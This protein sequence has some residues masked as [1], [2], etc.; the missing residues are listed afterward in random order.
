MK[1]G[2]MIG[3]VALIIVALIWH[4]LIPYIISHANSLV[5]PL[6][7]SIVCGTNNENICVFQNFV[8]TT[9]EISTLGLVAIGILFVVYG[10]LTNYRKKEDLPT[11]KTE[12]SVTK[13][14]E[15]LFS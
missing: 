7:G 12:N 9:F 14:L 13:I 10:M 1:I 3:G 15:D 8:K 11:T 2:L 5:D 6:G 4:N